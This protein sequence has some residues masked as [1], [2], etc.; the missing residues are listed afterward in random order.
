MQIRYLKVKRH[1]A[2]VHSGDLN[3]SV[4]SVLVQYYYL[5]SFFRRI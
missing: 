5:Q 1:L 3:Y 4:F 2:D